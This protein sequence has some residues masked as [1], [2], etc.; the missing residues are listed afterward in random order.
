MGSFREDPAQRKITVVLPRDA[1]VK[2]L[3]GMN[4]HGFNATQFVLFLLDSYY[5]DDIDTLRNYRH[6]LAGRLKRGVDRRYIE[7]LKQIQNL[8][9]NA[10]KNL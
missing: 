8:V 7:E 4:K 3:E 1:K 5:G 10:L 2:F 9:N 6:S